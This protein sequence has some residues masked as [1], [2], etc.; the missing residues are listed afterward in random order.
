MLHHIAS[1]V[2]ANRGGISSVGN[3]AATYIAIA[4]CPDLMPIVASGVGSGIDRYVYVRKFNDVSWEEVGAGSASGSGD[5][6][7]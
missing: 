1:F 7:T 3:S 4:I 2:A 6:P 5:Y